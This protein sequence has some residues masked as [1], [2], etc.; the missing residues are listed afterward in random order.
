M[1]QLKIVL[2]TWDGAQDTESGGSHVRGHDDHE[3]VATM[4]PRKMKEA[5]APHQMNG[6]E[7][8]LLLTCEVCLLSLEELLEDKVVK[9][10]ELV[11]VVWTM[12]RECH[13]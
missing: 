2:C 12:P 5:E 4:T 9:E 1:C 8:H 6:V 10:Q 7:I 3:C 13:L 11:G